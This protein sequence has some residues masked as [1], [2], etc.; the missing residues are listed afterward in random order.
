MKKP[1]CNDIDKSLIWPIIEPNKNNYKPSKNKTM[2]VKNVI[3]NKVFSLGNYENEKI[4]VE[5]EVQ[6]ED[7]IQQAMQKARQFV[8]FN[9]KVNGYINEIEQC[10]HIIS[11]P[12]D[13]TGSQVRRAMEKK[14][15]IEEVLKTGRKLLL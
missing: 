6:P 15:Q 14:S 2:Q 1:L 8:E 13:F 10:D 7:D 4:G 5:I 11:N 3:Y 12:D 9:H